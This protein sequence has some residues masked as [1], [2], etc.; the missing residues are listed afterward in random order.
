MAGLL[1]LAAAAGA[2]EGA[3][4]ATLQETGLYSDW[5]AKTV[6]DDSLCYSTRRGV[7]ST[8]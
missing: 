2:P 1:L 3:P 5:A 7:A 4:P 8:S 6:R